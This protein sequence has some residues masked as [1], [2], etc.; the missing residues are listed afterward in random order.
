MESLLYHDALATRH[1]QDVLYRVPHME[2]VATAV[3]R[4]GDPRYAYIFTFP[5]AFWFLGASAGYHALLAASVAEWCN[6][7]LKW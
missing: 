3:T 7:V 2:T 4:L 1:V 6:I 5:M